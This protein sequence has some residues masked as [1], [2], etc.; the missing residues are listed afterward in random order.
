MDFGEYT[1]DNRRFYRVKINKKVICRFLGEEGNRFKLLSMVGMEVVLLNLSP[2]GACIT[3][4]GSISACA[5]RRN[6]LIEIDIPI[7][8]RVIKL[9]GRVIWFEKT[10]TGVKAGISFE[11][12]PAED[13]DMLLRYLRE[14]L[15]FQ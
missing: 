5:V 8:D 1:Q 10:E 2:A 7:T 9:T 15:R 12:I 11:R 13:N 14:E 3:C 6:N 4:D